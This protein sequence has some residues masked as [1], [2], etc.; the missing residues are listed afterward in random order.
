L[1]AAEDQRAATIIRMTFRVEPDEKPE[2]RSAYIS[3]I[4]ADELDYTV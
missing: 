1:D 4:S 2:G 3:N